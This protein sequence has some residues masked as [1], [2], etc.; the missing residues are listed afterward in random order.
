[1]IV[2]KQTVLKNISKDLKFIE[3]YASVN[4]HKSIGILEKFGLSNMGLNKNGRSY[5]FKGDFDGLI[6]WFNV[7]N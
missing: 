1:V 2:L 4:N 5:H 6:K 7:K 3:A